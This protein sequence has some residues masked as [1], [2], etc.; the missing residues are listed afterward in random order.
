M[1]VYRQTNLSTTILNNVFQNYGIPPLY[2]NKFLVPF[3]SIPNSEMSVLHLTKVDLVD[4]SSND[5]V[6]V[7]TEPTPFVKGNVFAEKIIQKVSFLLMTL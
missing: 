6:G 3:V 5:T 4:Q 2:G 7:E 1:N